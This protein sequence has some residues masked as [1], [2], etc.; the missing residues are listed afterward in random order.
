VGDFVVDSAKIDFPDIAGVF[1]P[2]ALFLNLQN[3]TVTAIVLQSGLK[4]RA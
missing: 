1:Q 2:A 4:G 3:P